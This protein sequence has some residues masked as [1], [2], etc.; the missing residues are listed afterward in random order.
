MRAEVF[1]A[2]YEEAR[3][4]CSKVASK[5]KTVLFAS[6]RSQA[7]LGEVFSLS[8]ELSLFYLNRL[9]GDDYV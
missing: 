5:T 7:R 1:E 9:N 2:D 3:L 6:R 8:Q 4:K